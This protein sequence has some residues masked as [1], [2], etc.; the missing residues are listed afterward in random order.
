MAMLDL[1]K[2]C[3]RQPVVRRELRFRDE[4]PHFRLVSDSVDRQPIDVSMVGRS[5]YIRWLRAFLLDRHAFDVLHKRTGLSSSKCV[6]LTFDPQTWN[7]AYFPINDDNAYDRF[8]Q[9]YNVSRVLDSANTL[10]VTAYDEYSPLYLPATFA[11]TYLLGFALATCV[12]VHTALYHGRS[13]ING[14]KKIRMEPDDIHAKLMRNYPE[15]PDWW[16]FLFFVG[17]F[18]LMVVVVE[19]CE[20]TAIL[21]VF[22]IFSPQ[23]WHTTVPVWALLLAVFLPVLYMLPSG[24]IYA[25]TGQGV[26]VFSC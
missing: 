2:Q 24:F 15:V 11:M 26:R 8:G 19:V 1:P 20:G 18:L 17:F 10:N 13:L 21:F 6:M 5:T 22:L 7:L 12:L 16:Y 3:P 9:L 23:V 25:M 14:M 4:H